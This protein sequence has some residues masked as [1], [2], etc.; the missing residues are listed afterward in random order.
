MAR[1]NRKRPQSFRRQNE[2]SASSQHG[3]KT[4]TIPKP[5]LVQSVKEYGRMLRHLEGQPWL[6]LDTESD[7][8]YR[9]TP[10]V[11][12]I[13]LSAPA[14]TS[15]STTP[16]NPMQVLDYLID[17]LQL[18][19]LS[20]LG[21]IL[22]NDTT[23]VILHAADNDILTLQRDFNIRISQLF[24][25]QLAARILGRQG[26][27]LAQILQEEFN[28]VSDKRMQRTNW[29]QRPLTPQ[30]MIYAQTDTHYLP[31]LRARQFDHLQT[32]SRWNEAQDAFR[33]LETIAYSPPAPRTFWQMK[34]IR[35]LAKEDLSILQTLWRWR[36]RLAKRSDRPPFKILGENTLVAL[37]QKRPLTMTALRNIPGLNARQIERFGGEL[38]TAIRQGAQQPIPQ[39][40][41]PMGR[42]EQ[43]LS[44]RERKC[45]EVLRRWRTETASARRVDPDI[46]FSNDTLL[47]ITARQPASLAAL[48]EIP[49]IGQWKA[50]TYGPA[51]LELLTNSSDI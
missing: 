30:Q 44:S 27:G 22:A 47:Q 33:M 50:Q 48:Q 49:A 39:R 41:L 21:T 3:W 38:L 28:V 8:L 17:P 10:R 40:P 16:V 2:Q 11:C 24:D 34:Q 51:L 29:G 19:D 23:E 45:Y 32:A 14:A 15:A 4:S 20:A 13:Q 42:T 5:Q 7:S 35:A 6:A 31:T 18:H 46:V 37:A 26:V 36:E 9:Y 43:A 1:A 12:L 25:T